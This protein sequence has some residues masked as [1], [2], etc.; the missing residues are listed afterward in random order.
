MHE[1]I[2][3][4]PLVAAEVALV[5]VLLQR[6][7]ATHIGSRAA[8]ANRPEVI[9]AIYAGIKDAGLRVDVPLDHDLLN[10]GKLG[11]VFHHASRHLLHPVHTV[12][13]LHDFL[14]KAK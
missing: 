12:Q 14:S 4:L 5:H 6:V 7:P 9:E 3:I 8:K 11:E 13:D 2:W 10:T 1:L